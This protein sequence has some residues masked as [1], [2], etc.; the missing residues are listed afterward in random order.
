VLNNNHS[1]IGISSDDIGRRPQSTCLKFLSHQT[2]IHNNI[3]KVLI[4][5]A[6]PE[7]EDIFIQDRSQTGNTS[8]TIPLR[9]LILSRG[10]N[11]KMSLRM[12][13]W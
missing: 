4:F 9:S 10:Q 11:E 13:P 6:S 7:S 2:T 12:Y 5:D 3:S 1:L 8:K